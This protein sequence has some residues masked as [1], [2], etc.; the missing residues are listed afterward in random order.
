MEKI[1]GKFN[2]LDDIIILTYNLLGNVFNYVF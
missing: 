1:C 2:L